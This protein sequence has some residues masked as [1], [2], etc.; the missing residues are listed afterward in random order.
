MYLICFVVSG[1]R[2]HEDVDAGAGGQFAL[3]LCGGDGCEEVIAF[4]IH[5]PSRSEVIAGDED[6]GD[7][8]GSADGAALGLAGWCH[9]FN[10][11]G[12]VGIAAWKIIKD[13][14]GFGENV[15]FWHG[16]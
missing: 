5:R 3:I 7:A 14:K 4:F 15:I 6:W 8:I 11:E 13:V 9:C 10:P 1:H 12:A 16:L 2:V